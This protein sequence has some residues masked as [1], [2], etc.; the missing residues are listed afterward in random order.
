MELPVRNA[1]RTKN[2]LIRPP[3]PSSFS[4]VILNKSTAPL[5][6]IFED[7][8]CPVHLSPGERSWP[9][10]D[11]PWWSSRGNGHRPMPMPRMLC[12][13]GSSDSFRREGARKMK[14]LTCM[15]A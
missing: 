13:M 15:P 5:R 2:W 9:G 1:V 14:W 6:L 11:R 8:D 3:N 10:M 7:T 4:S 12:K